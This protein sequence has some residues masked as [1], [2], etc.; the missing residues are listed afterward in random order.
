MHYLTK[1]FCAFAALAFALLIA[2]NSAAFA[3]QPVATATPI[4]NPLWEPAGFV[5]FSGPVGQ[6]GDF[7]DYFTTLAS[8]YPP[9]NHGFNSTTGNVIPGQPHAGPYT[10]EPLAGVLANNYK[11]GNV[12]NVPDFAGHNGVILAFVFV[13]RAG[14]PTGTTPD[15]ANGP[16][17][18]N[19]V[20]PIHQTGVTLRNGATFDEAW[21]FFIPDV[22]SAIGTGTTYQGWS[23]QPI[24]EGE[25]AEFGPP[26]TPATGNYSTTIQYL[27]QQ[28][29]G[30]TVNWQYTVVP[31]PSSLAGASLIA[32]SALSRRRA[33]RG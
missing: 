16:M 28:G 22:N 20:Y 30:W 7:S 6:D 17:I 26:G 33:R 29:N 11:H 19:S 25:V 24:F 13:P 31:E 5:L 32:I 2:F 3:Q 10:G 15:S 9:P 18:P 23:H 14:A 12:Y 4:G 27:D 1:R 8:L 21:D